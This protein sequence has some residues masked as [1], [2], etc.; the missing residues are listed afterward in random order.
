MP[1]HPTLRDACLCTIVRRLITIFA[2][3]VFVIK[4]SPI[5]F[6]ILNR[7]NSHARYLTAIEDQVW[8]DH[9]K[10]VSRGFSAKCQSI[11]LKNSKHLQY[12][13]IAILQSCDIATLLHCYIEL[14]RTG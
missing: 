1:C 5:S 11:V 13:N 2:R 8:N 9:A 12:C 7:A 3:P 10:A 6:H 4:V 14:G